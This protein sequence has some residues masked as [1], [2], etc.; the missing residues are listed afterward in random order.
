LFF[1]KVLEKWNINFFFFLIIIQIFFRCSSLLRQHILF[2]WILLS[3]ED[4]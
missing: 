3:S 4:W 2:P 1:S